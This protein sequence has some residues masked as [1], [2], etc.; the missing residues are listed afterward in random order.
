MTAL[1]TNIAIVGRLMDGSDDRREAYAKIVATA[2]RVQ[3]QAEK[4]RNYRRGIRQLQKTYLLQ[5][6]FCGDSEREN[7]RLRQSLKET[8]MEQRRTGVTARAEP[9]SDTV[10]PLFFLAVTLLIVF[11]G[12]FIWRFLLPH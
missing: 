3:H 1:E 9:E 6:K 10:H 8:R 4:I 12:V 5:L 2:R 7:Q 11:G